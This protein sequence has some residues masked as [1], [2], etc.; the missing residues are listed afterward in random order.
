M[1][2]WAAQH[3]TL[4]LTNAFAFS[5]G[6]QEK[7]SLPTQRRNLTELTSLIESENSRWTSPVSSSSVSQVCPPL[8]WWFS[9]FPTVSRVLTPA[10]AFIWSPHRQTGDVD[11]HR[12]IERPSAHKHTGT[13][14]HRT[15]HDLALTCCLAHGCLAPRAALTSYPLPSPP[16]R[17]AHIW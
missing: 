7:R 3:L 13:H 6:S 8:W 17:S 5:F 14:A 9:F 1:G 10:T 4:T 15:K 16:G 2:L 11:A 12:G